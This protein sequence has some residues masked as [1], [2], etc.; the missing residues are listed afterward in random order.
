MPQEVR[1][2]GL[3]GSLASRSSTLAALR[4]GAGAQLQPMTEEEATSE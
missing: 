3:G 2:A 1:V 4:I